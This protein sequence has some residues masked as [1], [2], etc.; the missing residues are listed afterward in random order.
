MSSIIQ[1]TDKKMQK[2]VEYTLHE[3]S[4]LHTGKASPSMIENIAVDPYGSG[5][6]PIKNVAAITTPDSRMLVI[7]PWDKTALKAIEKAIQAANLGFNPRVDGN[8]VRCPIPELSGDR[9]KELVKTAHGMSEDGKVRIRGLRRDAIALLSDF[10]EDE[11][12]RFEKEIQTLTDKHIEE[13][14]KHLV[15]KEKELLQI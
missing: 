9:R 15:H 7:Q 14:A 3:F 10:S 13:I 5:S 6:M 2:A 8:V 4:T 12:K 1:D 11:R